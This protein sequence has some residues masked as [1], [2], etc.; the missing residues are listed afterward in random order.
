VTL[1][2]RITDADGLPAPRLHYRLDDNARAMLAHG[3]ERASEVLREAGATRVVVNPLV[4]AAGF[5]F[6]GT[7]RMG[8]DPRSSVVDADCR[9]HE[10][11]EILV[12]DGSAF[13]TAGA[14]NP[15]PTIQAIAL[16]A[17]TRLAARLKGETQ[18]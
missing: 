2:E 18:C 9:M 16:R 4:A 11:K 13:A 8:T 6:L 7:A 17:A 14:V 1:D 15:T 5:H 12:V 10:A 3:V